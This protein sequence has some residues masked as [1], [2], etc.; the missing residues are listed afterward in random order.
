[1]QSLKTSVWLALFIAFT[2][3][4]CK[5]ETKTEDN[6][7]NSDP[8]ATDTTLAEGL[9]WKGQYKGTLPC[10]D[11]EGIATTLNLN[12]DGTFKRVVFYR[13]KSEQAMVDRGSFSWD[14]E[15]L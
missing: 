9:T 11:C 2:L 8:S 10:A 15:R 14:E 4:S 1:M 6:V 13:G 7:G 12:A 3:T 5:N